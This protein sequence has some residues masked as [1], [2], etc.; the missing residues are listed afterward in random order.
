MFCT[1]GGHAVHCRDVLS[2]SLKLNGKPH[3][4]PHAGAGQINA[5]A[6]YDLCLPHTP[7]RCPRAGM[8]AT[9]A[10]PTSSASTSS[11]AATCQGMPVRVLAAV[12]PFCVCVCVCVCM[13][14]CVCVRICVCC[15]CAHVCVRVRVRVRARARAYVHAL[16]LPTSARSST[17]A[18]QHP[19]PCSARP[20]PTGPCSE[21]TM[22]S[23]P[24]SI[25]NG[26][27]R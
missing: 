14:A 15:V 17:T 1:D 11:L 2:Q 12:A 23:T 16:Q 8:R 22:A 20:L 19:P 21:C 10:H 7:S 24:R 6:P 13:R 4:R 18:P 26:R 25:Q 27:C 3:M 5:L 9:A